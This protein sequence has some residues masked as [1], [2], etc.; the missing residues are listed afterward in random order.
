MTMI[1][2][3]TIDLDGTLF[4]NVKNISKENIEAIK[5]CHELGVKIVIA[6]GRPIEGVRPV[7]NR[8]GLTTDKDYAIIYN[9]SKVLNVKTGELIFSS[10]ISGKTVKELY[11]EANKYNLNFHAFR[12]NE[13]L[14]T[15][16][17]NQYTDVEATINQI[18]DI[19]CDINS[20]DDD[21]EFLKAMIVDSKENLD[22]MEKNIDP[23]FKNDYS[24]VRSATIFLEFL[25]KT[26]DKG[27]ALYQL[28]KYLNVN[29]KD[30]MAI[31]DAGNDISMIKM[32]GIGVAMKNAFPEV[33]EIADF[34][35]LSN[36]ESG[37]AYAL[38]KF[39]IN[40]E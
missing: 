28:A 31:G 18:E 26:S 10:T 21:E 20:L 1:K 36:E 12:K 22:M 5:K 23:K 25:N 15:P 14:I 11:N 13:E 17:H 37:V 9:G 16:K 38:N 29:I 39:I 33:L 30:T 6:T 8:L 27:K 3:V 35:T 40:K 7:L 19:I 24:M 2:I 4:D 34:V 32:A